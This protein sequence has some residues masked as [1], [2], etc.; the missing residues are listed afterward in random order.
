[1]FGVNGT[2]DAD[3][4]EGVVGVVDLHLGSVGGEFSSSLR[5]SLGTREVDEIKI[6]IY[7]N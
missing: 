3:L 2:G 1:V 4:G 7:L 6:K 5:F